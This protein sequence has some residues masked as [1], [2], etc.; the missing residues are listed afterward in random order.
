MKTYRPYTP[1]QRNRISLDYRSLLTTQ[2][3]HKPLLVGV[4]RHV[5]RNNMGRI[6]VRHKGGGHKRTQRLVDFVY[7]DKMDIPA[8]VETVEY[9][10]NRS[11][12][13]SLV[14]NSVLA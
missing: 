4:K 13:L 10:P 7:S 8:K 3:P 5:G 9:D 1:S 12:F 11:G 14:T 2:T 6:T